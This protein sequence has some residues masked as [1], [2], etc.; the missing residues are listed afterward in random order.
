MREKKEV[1]N[2]LKTIN[3]IYIFSILSWRFFFLGF[4]WNQARKLDRR[5]FCVKKRKKKWFYFI[6][7][8]ALMCFKD[9]WIIITGIFWKIHNEVLWGLLNFRSSLEVFE[10][11]QI[12]FPGFLKNLI[13]LKFLRPQGFFKFLKVSQC[14]QDPSF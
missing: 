2:R 1:R 5:K 11:S 13:S 7:Y 12:F 9:L 3:I 6:I 10:A 4:W 8:W 14:F